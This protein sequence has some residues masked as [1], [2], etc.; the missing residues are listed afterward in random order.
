MSERAHRRPVGPLPKDV[1][2]TRRLL[3]MTEE[4]IR[5]DVRELTRWLNEQ[6]DLPNALAGGEKPLSIDNTTSE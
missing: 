6:P 3:G 5:R 1:A 2:A 4:S